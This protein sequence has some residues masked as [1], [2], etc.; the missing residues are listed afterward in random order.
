MD[1]LQGTSNSPLNHSLE[2]IN[3]KIQV[4]PSS[5]P[6][7]SVLRKQPTQEKNLYLTTVI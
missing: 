1:Q 6:A 2:T 7:T 3:H 5:S 4:G